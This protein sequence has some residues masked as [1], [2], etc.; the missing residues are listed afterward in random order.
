MRHD[1]RN[2]I[3]FANEPVGKLF[4]QMLVPTLIG[5]VSIV[6]LN[7][8]DGAFVG[9]GAGADALAAI[10]IAAPIFTILS[11]I[12]INFGIGG[13]VVAS[14]YLSRGETK[15]ARINVTQAFIGSIAVSTILSGIMLCSLKGTCRLFGS[16]EALLPLA[17]SYL[18]WVAIGSP[19]MTLHMV[20][21]FLIRLDGSPKYAMA[22]SIVGTVLNIFLD[23]L[24]I[25][26]F[27]WGLEGAAKATS[28]SFAIAGLMVV[29]YFVKMPKTLKLYRLRRTWKSFFLTLRNLGYQ[30]RMGFSAML[31]EIAVSGAEIA[32]N[33]V[34]I[35]YLGEVGVAAY[36]V[37]CY[38][39]PVI[40]MM[41]NA[42]VQSAQPIVSFAHGVDD[43]HR[44]KESF[45]LMMK[46]GTLAGLV[47]SALIYFG[48]PYIAMLFL[49]TGEAAY[50]ICAKGLSLFGTGVLFITLNIV[51]IGYMQSIEQ[52]ARATI[53]TLLRG[54]II[55]I[56]SFIFLPA[57]VGEKGLWLAIPLAE[58][59]T[60]FIIIAIMRRV[61]NRISQ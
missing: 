13:S 18:K 42:I 6:I 15:P 12:G 36:S 34:F 37:V 7:L 16:N 27:G 40:F 24:F 55:V 5:M 51:M 54:F 30:T 59:L 52:S 4:R 19:L 47:C 39:F 1:N 26:P 58:T 60:F 33:Y 53:G 25:F 29:Y 2:A 61:G 3:D 56:P 48:A 22:T 49:D 10:N 32:G 57:V 8:T 9:H 50:P 45:S 35:Y 11:G 14:I 41:A 44:L 23:W 28:F 31:G 17:T 21:V 46:W 20:G 38:C 43:R